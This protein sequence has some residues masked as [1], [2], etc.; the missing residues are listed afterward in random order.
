MKNERGFTI[1]EI[2]IAIIVL[3]VGLLGLVTTAALVTRMIARGQRSAMAATFAAQ[4]MERLRPAA[5]IDA[6]RVGGTDTLYRGST[7]VAFSNWVFVD[8]GNSYYRV[9]VVTTYKTD[10]NRVRVDTLEAGIP[11]LT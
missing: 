6:Q 1:I 8:E 9:R 3:T 4:R 5:C 2:I 11:C 7:W 10:Q